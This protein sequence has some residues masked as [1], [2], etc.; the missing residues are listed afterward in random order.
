MNLN[1]W[2]QV[3]HENAKEHGWWDEHRSFG[4]IAVLCHSEISE[5]V[6]AFRNGEAMYWVDE[7][8]KPQGV[9]TEMADCMIRIMDWAGGE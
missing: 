6:E 2:V 1:A 3:I 8:G 7:S 9:L 5:A 4:D